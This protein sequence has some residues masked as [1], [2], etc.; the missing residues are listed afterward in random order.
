MKQSSTILRLTFRVRVLP[1]TRDNVLP[2]GEQLATVPDFMCRLRKS[3]H[4]LPESVIKRFAQSYGDLSFRVLGKA[5]AIGD[6]GEDFGT[7]LY[8]LEV[9][10]LICNE[11]AYSVQD[12]LW[13]RSKLGLSMDAEGVGRLEKYLA[14]KLPVFVPHR[15]PEPS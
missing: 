13:R 8:A 11:W 4:W 1:W 15:F 14:S 12:I 6:L 7:G 5:G 9:D 2:G 3:Y 10:Y